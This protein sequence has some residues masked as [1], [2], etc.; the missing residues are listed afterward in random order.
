MGIAV[1]CWELGDCPLRMQIAETEAE[2]D[3]AKVEARVQ[4][5][6]AMA[7]LRVSF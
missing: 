7:I 1:L 6:A 4:T 3:K 2:R 5:E